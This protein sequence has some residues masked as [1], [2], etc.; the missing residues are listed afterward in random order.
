MSTTGD[1]HIHNTIEVGGNRIWS[2]LTT[3]LTVAGIVVIGY[4]L[5]LGP[6]AEVTATGISMFLV[7]LVGYMFKAGILRL[8]ETKDTEDDLA[9]TK[10]TLRRMYD[11]IQ[12]AIVKS[13]VFRLVLFAAGY[14]AIFLILR[15]LVAFGLGALSSLWMAVGVGLLAGALIIAQDRIWALIRRMQAK[16]GSN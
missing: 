15:A 7:T 10:S 9:F 4:Q 5:S 8:P 13:S 1:T 6:W 2:I 3:L 16:K 11:E 14:T 12:G